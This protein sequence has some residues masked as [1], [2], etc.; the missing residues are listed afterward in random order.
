MGAKWV[1]LTWIS[2]LGTLA[3][4]IFAIGAMVSL[5]VIG[6]YLVMM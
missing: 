2:S 5:F 1:F 3:T 6:I 4:M